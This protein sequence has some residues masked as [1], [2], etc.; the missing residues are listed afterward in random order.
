MRRRGSPGSLGFQSCE[1]MM[2]RLRRLTASRLEVDGGLATTGLFVE[3]VRVGVT[4]ESSDLEEEHATGPD[5]GRAA[6][7]GQDQFGDE[8]LHL[9]QQE[10]AEEN[11]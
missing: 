6:E 7:P 4:A 9:E 3:P 2:G 11:R 10:G 8:G 5:G 1:G